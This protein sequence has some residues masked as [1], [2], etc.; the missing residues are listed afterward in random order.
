M[1]LP[2]RARRALKEYNKKQQDNSHTLPESLD[3][4]GASVVHPGLGPTDHGTYNLV[5]S[6][7]GSGMTEKCSQIDVAIRSL[8]QRIPIGVPS[9]AHPL[10]IIGYVLL[11]AAVK[12]RLPC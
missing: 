1:L 8:L 10:R 3:D 7:R 2:E 12:M 11:P 9:M 6:T 5:R 4:A